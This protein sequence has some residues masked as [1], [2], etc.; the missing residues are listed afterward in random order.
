M[1]HERSRLYRKRREIR[2]PAD[3]RAPL[4]RSVGTELHTSPVR[5]SSGSPNASRVQQTL[6]DQ[7]LNRFMPPSLLI[8]EDRALVECFG[9]AEKFLRLKSRKPSLDVL[10]LMDDSLRTTLSGAIGRTRKDDSPVCFSNVALNL[11]GV[12]QKFQSHDHAH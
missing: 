5:N 12:D 4:N 3:F 7:L 9:G 1:L 11:D 6:H 8:D 2:L 10:D